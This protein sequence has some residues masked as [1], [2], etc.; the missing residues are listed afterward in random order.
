MR[1]GNE[2]KTHLRRKK[3]EFD[4]ASKKESRHG[5]RRRKTE[6]VKENNAI[7][8]ARS[9]S[10]DDRDLRKMQ[11]RLRQAVEYKNRHGNFGEIKGVYVD[12]GISAKDMRRPK[13]Q[14][15]LRAIRNKEIDL[16]MVTEL[17]R[18]SCNTRDF[19]EMWDMMR[20]HGCRFTSLR[21]DFDTTNAAGE[22]VLFQLMNLA[23]FE[24]RQ[25]SERVE[26]NIAARAAR[27]LY[28]GGPVPVGYKSMPDKP[29]YLEIDPD[30]AEMV[31]AAFTAFLREGCLAHAAIWLNENG[32]G[33][34]K[35]ME[36]GGRFKRVSHFTVDNLQAILRNKAYIGI[37]I[38]SVKGEPKETK[39]VW[40]ALIDDVTFQRVGKILDKNRRK[41]KPQIT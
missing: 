5:D 31:N 3:Q 39:A 19:I 18:L 26:A 2:D 27:G 22:L 10:K 1:H 21:E 23:Q 30:M 41:Y 40:P 16:V 12:P 24:R 4:S 6:D 29:G 35:H 11:D 17:S 28:N 37:K 34:K 38:Y 15:L 32:Y 14:E 13:L 33:L 25:T 9:R 8:C 7:D 20:A 36:G